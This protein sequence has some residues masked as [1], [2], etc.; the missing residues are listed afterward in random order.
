MKRIL[1]TLGIIFLSGC[2]PTAIDTD[3]KK[4]EKD[5]VVVIDDTKQLAGDLSLKSSTPVPVTAS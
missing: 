2:S 1:L 4:E 5:I 3:A